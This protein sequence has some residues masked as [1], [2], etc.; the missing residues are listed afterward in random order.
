MDGFRL[1]EV[2]LFSIV[3]FLP[4]VI[5]SIY[6][7]YDRI[8]F[9]KG[10]TYIVCAILLV[11]QF[12]TRYWSAYHNYYSDVS[13]SILR[14]T[15]FLAGYAILFDIR[16]R[17]V[18]FVELIFVNTGNYIIA[19]AVCLERN[20]FP[21]I[22]HH[23]YCW[24][25]SVVMILLHLVLTLPLAFFVGKNYKPMISNRIIGNIWNYYWIIPTIFYI[26]FQYEL[27]GHSQNVLDT[28]TNPHDIF[29]LTIIQLGSYLIYHLTIRLDK[30]LIHNMDMERQQHYSDI[31]ALEYKLLEERIED[32]RCARH[33]LRH[34]MVVMAGYLDEENYEALKEYLNHYRESLPESDIVHF[35][36]NRTIN[37]VLQYFAHQAREYQIDFEALISI[38]EH[39]SISD[40]DITILLGNLLENAV[41]ACKE[42]P[43]NRKITIR[44]NAN[45][46]TVFFTIDNTCVNEI[47]KNTNGQFQSTKK[48]GAG[49]GVTSAQNIVKHYNGVFTAE[50][51]KNM[52]YVSFMLNL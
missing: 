48:K 24:H 10:L 30:E 25:S 22:K 31:A 21:H 17:K 42:C 39:L 40:T 8:R 29:F 45:E 4:F 1:M 33:D 28:I 9:S 44:G 35:C 15:V 41:D 32:A 50:K 16:F 34:H 6:T 49:L 37:N 47:K 11:V 20:L 43:D 51:N 5:L 27:N 46:N 36:H 38:P 13:M 18:L 19:A 26:I 14:L 2:A 12:L 52:F 23:L 3:I 7:F